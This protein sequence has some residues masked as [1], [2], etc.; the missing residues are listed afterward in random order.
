MSEIYLDHAA[1]TS[2]HPEVLNAMLP[3]LTKEYYNPSAAYQAG[4]RMKD[5]IEEVREFIASCIHA[6]PEEIYY[7]GGGTEGDNWILQAAYRNHQ[8]T[9]QPNTI[10]KVPHFITSCIE[11]HAILHTCEELEN[12]GAEVSYLPVDPHGR[13]QISSL[14]DAIKENTCLVSIQYANNEIGTLQPVEEIGE[15][16]RKYRLPFHTDAVQAC[17]HVPINVEAMHITSLSASAHKFHGPKGVGFLYVNRSFPLTAYLH[18]GGQER[19]LRAG[20]ENVAGIIG[21]GKALELAD[22]NM[23]QARRHEQELRD[24]MICRILQEIPD[25]IINGHMIYRLS[26]NINLAFRYVNGASLLVLLDNEEVCVSA[27]SACNS[28][29]QGPSHVIR[30]LSVPDDYAGGVIR[31][32]I[33][34]ENTIEELEHTVQLLKRY[35]ME[36]RA[37]SPELQE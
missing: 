10:P 4:K 23:E 12:G 11:H 16:C 31:M 26:N 1:T 25:T 30:A 37:E 28:G 33:G 14:R 2:M 17:G 6:H 15:C 27:G 36:L 29:Q 5:R 7:T 19:H 32:T 18:G 8:K 34:E 21:M 13:I 3:Y 20:T 24:Y 35:V 22:R 9:E